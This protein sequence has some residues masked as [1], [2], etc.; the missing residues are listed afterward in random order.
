MLPD[1]IAGSLQP[2]S[3]SALM[4]AEDSDDSVISQ[5]S[6]NKYSINDSLRLPSTSTIDLVDNHSVPIFS[7][8][9][10]NPDDACY[11]IDSDSEIS[12]LSDTAGHPTFTTKSNTE[13]P[14]S[15]YVVPTVTELHL[16]LINK[17]IC[18]N[19]NVNE[20]MARKSIK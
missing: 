2:N 12:D 1:D 16:R 15:P 9:Y 8:A 5:S 20:F 19:G 3:S 13:H 7:P 18:L 6:T 4:I 11:F 10:S 14:V 17:C